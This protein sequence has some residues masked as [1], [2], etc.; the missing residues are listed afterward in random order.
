MRVNKKVIN[1]TS[2]RYL[3]CCWQD[4]TQPGYQQYSHTV[5]EG[6]S[7]I[8]YVFCRERHLQYFL[9]SSRSMGN[10]P[11]GFGNLHR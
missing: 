6:A 5:R 3:E 9:N 8:T 4:C 7:T 2:G 1:M 11:A 10:L